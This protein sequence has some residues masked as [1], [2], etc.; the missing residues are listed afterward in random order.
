MEV[1]APQRQAGSR[2]SLGLVQAILD[3]YYE[4]Q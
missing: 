3:S 4:R 2:G 1:Q